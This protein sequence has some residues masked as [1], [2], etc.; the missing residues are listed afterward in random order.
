MAVIIILIKVEVMLLMMMQIAVVIAPL[1]LRGGCLVV[2]LGHVVTIL[3]IVV[4]VILGAGLAWPLLQRSR[5]SM[6]FWM[7]LLMS[8]EMYILRCCPSFRSSPS[9]RRLLSFSLFA[10]ARMA[11]RC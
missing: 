10:R 11:M 6:A 9:T 8:L 3:G 2:L 4:Q 7:A 1:A 5:A